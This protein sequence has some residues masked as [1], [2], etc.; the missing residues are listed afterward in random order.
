MTQTNEMTVRSRQT[1]RQALDRLLEGNRRFVAG[2][3]N[4]ERRDAERR[5]ELVSGQ[6]P[7]ATVLACVDSRVPVEY[8][9]D[10]GFGDVLVV[11]TAGQALDGTACVGSLQ[12]GVEALGLPLLLVLGHTGCGAVAAAREPGVLSGPLR[13]LAEEIAR[14][15]EDHPVD[16]P[17]AASIENIRAT[18]R[19]IR[20]RGLA[21]PDGAPAVVVGALFDLTTGVVD[22]VDDADLL[23][24]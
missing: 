1:A 20:E 22:V 24:G 9:F 21:T 6:T 18:V 17:R 4:G 12:F 10:E 7:I 14:R 23:D 11:R 3:S 19:E 5:A 16:D 2:A 8:V 13:A 15:L